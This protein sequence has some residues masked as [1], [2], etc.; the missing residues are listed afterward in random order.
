MTQSTA[1]ATTSTKALARFGS[2]EDIKALMMRQASIFGIPAE[3]VARADVQAA[4]VKAT[5]Y[6]I[7]Y[8]Y[9]AFMCICCRS[10]KR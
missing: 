3:D 1:L 8:G 2:E 5:Q 6:A 7:T 4:L 9:L 10:T